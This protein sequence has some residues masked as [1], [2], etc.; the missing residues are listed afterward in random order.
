M[1][2]QWFDLSLV[3]VQPFGNQGKQKGH[4]MQN[5]RLLSCLKKKQQQQAAINS[6]SHSAVFFKGLMILVNILCGSLWSTT[7]NNNAKKN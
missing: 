4:S 7:W 5:N 1:Q 6:E 3:Y 2:F